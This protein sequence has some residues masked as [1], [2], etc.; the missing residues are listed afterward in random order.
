MLAN[1]FSS[2]GDG[3]GMNTAFL[4]I[5]VVIATGVVL[6]RLVA[7]VVRWVLSTLEAIAEFSL[8][9]GLYMMGA[10]AVAL[11][12]AFGYVMFGT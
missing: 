7:P 1:G 5:V 8:K 4:V 10:G 2:G 12:L 3:S 9:A 6:Y 11:V